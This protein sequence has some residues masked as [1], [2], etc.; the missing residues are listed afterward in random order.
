MNKANEIAMEPIVRRQLRVETEGEQIPLLQCYRV[1]VAGGKEPY[2]PP[3]AHDAG[4]TYE[5]RSERRGITQF[6]LKKRY[7]DIC[8][9]AAYLPPIGISSHINIQEI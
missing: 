1:P 3:N 9:K 4:G 8:L 2:R 5:Y 6:L 7:Q